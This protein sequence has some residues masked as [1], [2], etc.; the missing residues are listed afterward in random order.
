MGYYNQIKAEETGVEK[1]IVENMY[2][3]PNPFVKDVNLR[4][5]NDGV[6]DIKV[7]DA[8][9]RLVTEQLYNADKG[10]ICTLSIDNGAG[11][12]YVVV[13]QNGKCLKSFKVVSQK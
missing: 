9:G 7:Y 8:Q 6:Y 4:F 5:A 13:S 3:Y 11:M 10:E 1:E 12:Y 2:V